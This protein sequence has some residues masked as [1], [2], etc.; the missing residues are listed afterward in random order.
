MSRKCTSEWHVA[1]WHEYISIIIICK[2]MSLE[3]NIVPA[4]VKYQLTA[5]QYFAMTDQRTM[6]PLLCILAC[7]I[8][9]QSF[10]HKLVS[11]DLEL[12]GR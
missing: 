7:A 3:I 1:R 12:E 2:G 5:L 9:R 4:Q 11:E 8:V 10:A 6:V